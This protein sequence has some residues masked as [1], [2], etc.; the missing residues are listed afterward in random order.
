MVAT[1]VL[2]RPR[3][4]FVFRDPKGVIQ[5]RELVSNTVVNAGRTYI[6]SASLANGTKIGTWYVGL[7]GTTPSINV[8][9]T[10][11]SH[12]GWVEVTDY[13][14]ATRP[15][16]VHGGTVT[17]FKVTNVLSKA[18]FTSTL[19]GNVIGGAFLTSASDKGGATGTLVSGAAFSTGDKQLNTFGTLDITIEY[20][21]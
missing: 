18:R 19:D 3:W 10:M 12:A 13:S 14:E 9:D 4:N 21:F 5:H 20:Q 11:A 17:S 16:W 1:N 2:I 8:L 15:S 7:M 6:A